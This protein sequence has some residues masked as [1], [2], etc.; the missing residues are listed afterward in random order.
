MGRMKDWGNAFVRW[1]LALPK[2]RK[3]VVSLGI[4]VVTYLIVVPLYNVTVEP[5]SASDQVKVQCGD[6]KT[7]YVSQADPRLI[8]G[9]ERNDLG[10]IC[11]AP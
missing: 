6:V 4:V 10:A 8:S 7:V 5:P 2:G 9:L 3:Y 11:L 1:F